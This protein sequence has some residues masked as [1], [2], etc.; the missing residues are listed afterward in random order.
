MQRY[1]LIKRDIARQRIRILYN[2]AIKYYRLDP[3]LSNRYVR[4]IQ[5]IA[6]RARVKIDPSI[7][8]FICKKCGS[9]LIPGVTARFRINS[10]RFTHLTITCLKCGNIRRIRL[11]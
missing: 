11:A 8:L 7:K 1:K 9:L 5:R 2:L 4:L 6:K 3:E 10:G